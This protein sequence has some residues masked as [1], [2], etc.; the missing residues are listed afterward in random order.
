M[1]L[2]ALRQEL[3][4]RGVK[5]APSDRTGMV[6]RLVQATLALPNDQLFA[7]FGGAAGLVAAPAAAG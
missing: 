5:L 1:D 4:V 2:R 3:A 7:E 6:E